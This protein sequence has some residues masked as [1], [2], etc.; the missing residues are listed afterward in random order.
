VTGGFIYRGVEF[1]SLDGYYFFSDYCNDI[2]YSLHDS[3][4]QWVLTKHGQFPGNNFSTFGEDWNGEIYVAGIT[5][6]KV[7]KLTTE[8]EQTGINNPVLSPW[9]IYP[10]PAFGQ[11]FVRSRGQ[12][13]HPEK[14]R[15]INMSG[16]LI[17]EYI[18]DSSDSEMIISG[19][20]PGI[21]L[22]E[23]VA[24]GKI[25]HEKLIIQQP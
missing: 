24:S 16:E 4:G 14:I 18:P 21:F 15:I 20:P 12:N 13:M 8:E 9:T 2:L 25:M 22:V 7:Y 3:S 1:P 17:R 11:F 10:N 5:S 19:I 23:I 6:G